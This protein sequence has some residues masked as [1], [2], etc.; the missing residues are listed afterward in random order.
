MSDE[1]FRKTFGDAEPTKIGS[2]WISGL[3]GVFLG[4]LAVGGTLCLRFPEI[5]TLP[6][7]RAKYPIEIMRVLIQ[8]AIF[9]SFVFAAASAIMRQR[10]VLA[11]TGAALALAAAALGGGTVPLPQEVGTKYGIGLD[12]FLLDLFVMTLVFVPLE[13]IW[14]LHPGQGT[15]RAEWTTD[16]FYFVA[17]HLPAQL[18]TFLMLAPA[19]LA[20]PWLAIPKLQA[21]V[22]NWPFVVQLLAVILVADLSQYIVHRAFHKIPALWRFHAVHHSIRTM[23]WIAGSRSHFFDIVVTRGLIMIPLALCGFSQGAIVGYILFVSFHATFSHLDFR[24]RTIWLEN[25]LVTPRYHHWHHSA[26]DEAIDCNF[27]IH[28]PWIDRLFGTHHFPKDKWPKSY[29][30]SGT[31]VR[32]GFFRQFVDPFLGR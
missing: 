14:P 10:K 26:E 18:L 6:D 19:A 15:F 11:L 1:F 20:A 30:L 2:G 7:A 22:G 25:Y 5:L 3:I 16:S 27:A 24:P 4:L 21:F 23:D 28:F 9:A 17:T 31:S 12:W 8:G 29:G 13:R 32:P